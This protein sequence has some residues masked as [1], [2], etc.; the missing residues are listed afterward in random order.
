[1]KKAFALWLVIISL[2]LG[3]QSSETNAEP[4]LTTP[5][6]YRPVLSTNLVQIAE[7]GYRAVTVT[8]WVAASNYY[9]MVNGE[10]YRTYI[11]EK[12]FRMPPGDAEGYNGQ[13]NYLEVEQVGH[14]SLLC[15]L[16]YN[17]HKWYLDAPQ[18]KGKTFLREVII[19]N[20]PDSRNLVT[21]QAI[22][23]HCMRVEN[24]I[25]NGVSLEAYDCG[26]VPTDREIAKLEAE[27]SAREKAEAEERS[28][29]LAAARAQQDQLRKEKAEKTARTIFETYMRQATNGD[30]YSQFRVGGFYLNGQ[31]VQTNMT[32]AREWLTTAFKNGYSPAT[33]LL[34][35]IKA[36][37]PH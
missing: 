5:P 17:D 14:E 10:T 11:S 15:G 21:G 24:F 20:F 25:T 36:D 13:P 30:A 16:Y 34:N 18:G 37:S 3:A 12:W 4:V 29:R 22:Y 7:F 8:N 2:K 19:Y 26:T 31:G 33:N 32:A 35:E 9:R 23:C 27:D 6:K 28:R 1:M